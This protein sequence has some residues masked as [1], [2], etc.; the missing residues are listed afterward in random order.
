MS[1][2]TDI[3]DKLIHFTKGDSSNEAFGTLRKIIDERRLVA[4]NYMIRGGYRCVCFTEAPLVA[5]AAGFVNG[6]SVSRYA[7]F[8]LMFDKASVFAAGGRPVI[9][10]PESEFGVLP[11]EIGWRHVRYEPSGENP[12]DFTWEREWRVPGD[13]VFAAEEAVIVLPDGEWSDYLLDIHRYEQDM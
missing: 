7:P 8:G 13:L 6:P 10:Q 2:R 5:L 9:Y 12:I 1:L 11:A 3:S 4:G